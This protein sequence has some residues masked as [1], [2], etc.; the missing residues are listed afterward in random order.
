MRALF[1]P[2]L[3]ATAACTAV[4][5]D[6][7]AT[8]LAEQDLA[9]RMAEIEAAS[10]GRLG[11][12]LHSP[13]A[14]TVFLHRGDERFAMCSSFK[15]AL[16]AMA[17]ERPGLRDARLGFGP[18]EVLGYA[19]YAKQRAALGW[20]SGLEAARHSVTISDNTAANLLLAELGGPDGFTAWLRGFGDDKTRLDRNEPAL[21]ENA[22]GD[23]RDTTT[24]QAHAKLVA[25]LL[26][27]DR[28]AAADRSLLREWLV[29]TSTGMNRLRAGIPDGWQAGDKTGTCGSGAN[30]QVNDIAVFETP[31]GARY[32]LAV[33]LDRPSGTTAEAEAAI[34][35][36]ARAIVAMLQQAG[37]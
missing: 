22:P 2:L 23:P 21:N 35:Q 30:G 4:P 36:A 31:D 1:L 9:S 28:L 37:A 26:W 34:A 24:P 33:Y 11:V 19:P 29:E 8:S 6:E 12:A 32:V 14:G 13:D 5:Q 15:L 18:D 17:L 3:L 16:A 25:D 10:G 7:V 27:G 20:M